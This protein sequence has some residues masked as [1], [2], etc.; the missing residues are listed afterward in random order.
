MNK[1][2]LGLHKLFEMKRAVSIKE[3]QDHLIR[4]NLSPTGFVPT[5]GALH[6]GHISLVRQAIN[7]CK[8][9]T[10]SI[11]VNPNQFND[12]EDLKNYPR[13]IEKDLDLLSEAMRENDIV[14]TPEP[15]EIYPE[16]DTRIFNF[17][18]LDSV[19]EGSH[20]PGHFNGVAQVVSRLFDIVKSDNAYFGQKDFQQL[21]I[22]KELVRQTGNKTK[23]MSCP[24]IRE[25]DGLALSSRNQLLEPHVR[26]EA[27]IIYSTISK[28][29]ELVKTMEIENVRKYVYN[30]INLLADFTV[31][32]FEIADDKELVTITKKSQ[33][34]KNKKYFACIAVRAGRIRLIDNVE[35]SLF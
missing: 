12:K 21:T 25:S 29:A 34:K 7:D 14:F 6:K 2:E 9:I 26:K 15:E 11:F 28:A 27:A 17:G 8:M 30:N 3:L 5:M 33:I 1:N 22:I 23:I 4:M 32:Y 35:I 13:T 18:K 19:M 16:P 24:I 10:V 20:R 31:E